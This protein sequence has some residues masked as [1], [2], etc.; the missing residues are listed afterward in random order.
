[1]R[2]CEAI[3][4]VRR[5]LTL[6]PHNAKLNLFKNQHS[7]QRQKVFI[8]SDLCNKLLRIETFVWETWERRQQR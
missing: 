4:K 7:F 3:S 8:L 5:M 2:M 6:L 1:M